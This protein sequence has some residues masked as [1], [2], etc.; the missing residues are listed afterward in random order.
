VISLLISLLA[1]KYLVGWDVCEK[2]NK[3]NIIKL[4]KII[5]RK[6]MKC[7]MG[8]VRWPVVERRVY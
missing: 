5:M 7:L 2:S 3:I 6:N 4:R 1:T 8:I